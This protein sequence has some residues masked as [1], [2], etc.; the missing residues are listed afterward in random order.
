[1]AGLGTL[2]RTLGT[3]LPPWLVIP[4]AIVLLLA[5]LPAWVETMRHKQLRG[6][7]RRMVRAEEAPRRAL[8]DRALALARGRGPRLAV[9]VEQAMKYGQRALMDE[10]LAA[11]QAIDPLGADRL[12][13]QQRPDSPKTVLHPLEVSVRVERLLAEGMREAAEA[14]LDEALAR[15]PRDPDL[16]ALRARVAQEA[17]APRSRAPA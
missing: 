2:V 5:F 15:H 7:V 11:L 4:V 10:A 3:V 13:A 14:R 9:I 16:L 12:R 8:I 17:T 6:L 1:M